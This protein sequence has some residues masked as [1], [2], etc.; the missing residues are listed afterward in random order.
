MVRGTLRCVDQVDAEVI[1]I[2]V[3][4]P[5]GWAHPPA[6]PD[7]DDAFRQACLERSL[8]VFVHAPYLINFA[9]PSAETRRRS[10]V[11]LE[12]SLRRGGAVGA[13]GVVV[14]AGSAVGAPWAE[15]MDQV[16]DAV[17]PLLDLGGPRL[18][19][20]PTAGGKGA[21]AA[22]LDSITAY[23]DVLDDER[24]GLCIDTCHLHAAGHDL[25]SAASM[26]ATFTKLAKRVGPG[27]IELLH[28]NDTRDPADSRRDRHESIGQGTIGLD[29][30]AGLFTT[31]ALRGVPMVV[32]TQ[33]AGQAADIEALKQLRG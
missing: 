20:E 27:R 15:A 17:L 19:I 18:L 22:D 10:E 21:L 28:V 16:R 4:N 1:Q 3:A 23:L 9:S 11:A 7:G 13:S 12:F 33:D 14:H 2:F 26:R 30:F 32:E 29:A 25:S 5:R 6:N 24:V 8:P 31:P